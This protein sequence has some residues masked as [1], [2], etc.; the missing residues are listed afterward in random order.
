MGTFVQGSYAKGPLSTYG[1]VGISKIAYSY[2][3]H[4]TVA[5][6]KIVADPISTLQW[7]GGAMYDV[8]DNISVFGNFGIVEKPPI[9]DNVMGS[10]I[11]ESFCSKI[12][13]VSITGNAC[14][15]HEG[16]AIIL[17]P[18]C[19]KFNDFKIS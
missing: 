16:H 5:D 17:T 8:S 15:A 13:T 4:F 11:C 3:D 10:F 14:L 1:M 2:Q 7:K 9:M 18:L 12:F 19:L 6:E